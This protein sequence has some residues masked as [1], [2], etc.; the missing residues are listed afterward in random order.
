MLTSTQFTSLSHSSVNLA[1]QLNSI[2]KANNVNAAKS[3]RTPF[4]NFARR[5]CDAQLRIDWQ[6]PMNK[7]HC[8]ILEANLLKVAANDEI[9]KIARINSNIENAMKVSRGF[10]VQLILQTKEDYFKRAINLLSLARNMIGRAERLL[11][12]SN[13]ASQSRIKLAIIRTELHHDMAHLYTLHGAKQHDDVIRTC[14]Q[15]SV[16]DIAFLSRVGNFQNRGHAR[17]LAYYQ[18]LDL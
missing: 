8:F 14:Q 10:E 7:A 5:V 4:E 3:Q 13:T 17:V 2:Y 11:V 6:L 16:A 18:S 15:L 9:K 12:A 1:L